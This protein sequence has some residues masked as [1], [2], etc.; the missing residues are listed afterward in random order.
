MEEQETNHCDQTTVIHNC[1]GQALCPL[2]CLL[3]ALAKGEK[4]L[5]PALGCPTSAYQQQVLYFTG[6][7]ALQNEALQ[8]VVQCLQSLVVQSLWGS[9][10]VVS[11]KP[12]G[13]GWGPQHTGAAHSQHTAGQA[14]AMT[15]HTGSEGDLPQT[16]RWGRGPSMTTQ[17]IFGDQENLSLAGWPP[18]WVT[19][20]SCDGL[21]LLS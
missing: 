13:K 12:G 21:P 14:P 9:R 17:Q 15:V 10:G 20:N 19:C 4:P 8:H 16:R 1:P 6:C 11:A 3:W 18:W 5:S 2:G 7:G